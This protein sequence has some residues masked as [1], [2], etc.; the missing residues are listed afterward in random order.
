MAVTW[1]IME[2]ERETTNQGVVVAHWTVSDSEVVG[3]GEDAV[4]HSGSSYGSSSF[5]P[6]S[7]AEGFT[8]FDALTEA[9]VIAWVKSSLGEQGVLEIES[10]IAAQIAESKIPAVATGLPW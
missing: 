7:S 1:N 5:T 3:Q 2:L 9:D 8:E 4:T 6:D 10:R